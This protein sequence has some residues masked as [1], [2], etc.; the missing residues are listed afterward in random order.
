MSLYVINHFKN[1]QLLIQLKGHLLSL[2]P[3][4]LISI[5]L[6]YHPLVNSTYPLSGNFSA[7]SLFCG[8]V[9]HF[10]A[11]VSGNDTC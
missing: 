4:L 9:W 3:N 10:S 1:D 6:F 7:F 11:H 5:N 2:K 8:I